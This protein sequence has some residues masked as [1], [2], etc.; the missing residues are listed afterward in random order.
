MGSP[1]YSNG[2]FNRYGYWGTNPI[3]IY[4]IYNFIHQSDFQHIFRLFGHWTLHIETRWSPS[5]RHSHMKPKSKVIVFVLNHSKSRGLT[6]LNMFL[7]VSSSQNM[8][9]LPYWNNT[10]FQKTKKQP[11]YGSSKQSGNETRT[12]LGLPPSVA[13]ASSPNQFISRP[14]I[15]WRIHGAAIW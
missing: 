2:G 15:P 1:D 7:Q 10:C 3:L 11:I 5:F 6:C 13:K 14:Y 4:L 12:V 8:E 9:L